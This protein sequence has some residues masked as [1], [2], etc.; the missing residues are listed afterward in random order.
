MEKMFPEF[1]EKLF[2]TEI[3]TEYHSHPECYDDPADLL[4]VYIDDYVANNTFAT[5]KQIVTMYSTDIKSA[6]QNYQQHL[7]DI[8]ILTTPI[9]VVY[10]KLA[11]STLF[12]HFY[13]LIS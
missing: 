3:T 4:E 8:D 12:I 7:G 6:M 13:P 11:F 10:E 1:D 2:I 5:N 9:D